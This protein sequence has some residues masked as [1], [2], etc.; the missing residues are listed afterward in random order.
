MDTVGLQLNFKKLTAEEP[1]MRFV[2][3]KRKRGSQA[4]NSAFSVTIP[5]ACEM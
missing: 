1:D 4:P 3:W 2:N 5:R